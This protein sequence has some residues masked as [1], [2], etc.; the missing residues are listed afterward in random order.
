ME[1]YNLLTG[2]NVKELPGH[3]SLVGQ[4]MNADTPV[5]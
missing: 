3:R 2:R 5:Y 1:L 4:V